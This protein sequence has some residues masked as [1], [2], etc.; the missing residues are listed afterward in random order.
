MI[1][2]HR[3]GP[4]NDQLFQSSIPKER[5]GCVMTKVHFAG[6]SIS[7]DGFGAGPEQSLENPLGQ[8][9]R[10]LHEWMF[11]TR[12]F[13]TMIGKDG[14]SD[15]VDQA[16]PHR[17]MEGFGAFI[18]GRNMFG[19]AGDNWGGPDWNGGWGD[20]PPYHAATVV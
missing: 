17:S 1:A 6:F 11:G 5:E 2:G 13:R 10:E 3:H 14:G 9:G 18:L 8:R 20:N 16:Y 19:P 15:G 12:M 7:L 4:G